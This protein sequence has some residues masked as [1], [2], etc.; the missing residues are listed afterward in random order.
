MP[1]ADWTVPFELTSQVW[2]G[3]LLPFNTAIA[4]TNGTGYYRL[5][6]ANCSLTNNVR[7][8]KDFVPQAPGA[9]LHRRFVGGME[10]N[11]AVQ[12][13]AEGTIA[14]DALLQEMVDELMGYLYG[15]LNAVDNEG[16]IQ[17]TPTGYATRM[18]DNLR[19]LSYPAG[20]QPPG[21][22]YEVTFAVDTQYPYALDLTQIRTPLADGS[23]TTITN[24]GTAPIYP[25]YQANKL[26]NVLQ[27]GTT[28]FGIQNVT[29]PLFFNGPSIDWTASN[30]GVPAGVISAAQ[31]GEIDTFRNTI[32]LDGDGANLLPGVQMQSAEFWAI[33][34]GG[35]T[36]IYIVGA[37]ADM[38]WQAAWS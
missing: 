6:H 18:L 4:F 3:S 38:L 29:A 7:E 5:N 15:L 12:M 32:F 17:W 26:N 28:G 33:P 22:P 16:R 20:T 14:C 1:V 2:S 31:Y 37:D 9:I 36:D 11:L 27:G 24:T 30:P 8:T 25:V 19:L 23:T 21:N 13:W 34:P 10:M 35:S